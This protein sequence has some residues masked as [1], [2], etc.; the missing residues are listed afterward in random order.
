M[1]DEY[2]QILLNKGL[3]NLTDEDMKKFVFFIPKQFTIPK[4]RLIPVNRVGVAQLMIEN[5][6]VVPALREAIK[7]FKKLGN[8][9]LAECCKEEK[10]KVDAKH[11]KVKRETKSVNKKSQ[12]K[13][14]PGASAA[15]RHS[16]TK[17]PAASKVLPQSK[18]IKQKDPTVLDP[19]SKRKTMKVSVT[20]KQKTKK[21]EE[22]NKRGC[23]SSQWLI[24]PSSRPVLNLPHDHPVT[25]K[26]C[27]Q[28]DLWTPV[29]HPL[30]AS[31]FIVLEEVPEIH[32]SK[33]RILLFL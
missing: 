6:G 16:A 14:I 24:F 21:R 3:E 23:T 9:S 27:L 12:D 30:S 10:K 8:N 1:E 18:K 25:S 33:D 2:K 11:K 28:V 17:Q 20:G 29:L 22:E 15:S 5:A 26:K 31:F 19:N 7:I 32:T 13:K 4:G